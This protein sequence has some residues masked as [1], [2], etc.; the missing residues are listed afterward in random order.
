MLSRVRMLCFLLFGCGVLSAQIP[1]DQPP[2]DTIYYRN[3]FL[4][5]NYLLK[6]KPLTLPVMAFF[7]KDYPAAYNELRIA[8]LSDQLCVAGYSMGSLFTIG[9]LM[10][11]RQDKELSEGLIK[12]G[13]VGIGAG[14][15]FQLVAG[16][17]KFRAVRIYNEEVKKKGDNKHSMRVEW[18]AGAMSAGISVQFD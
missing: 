7:M 11:S 13:V 15:V 18:N 5:R 12:M 14:L 8:Q 3:E 2:T 6:G 9:G 4:N 1:G 17:Y 10:F 16:K